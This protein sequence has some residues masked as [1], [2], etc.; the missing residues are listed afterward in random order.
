MTTSNDLLEQLFQPQSLDRI[1]NRVGADPDQ[2]RT[3]IEQALP[4]LLAGLERNAADPEGAR[5]LQQAL[6]EDR[7]DTLLDDLDGYLAGSREGK[8]ADG[9]GILSHILGDRQE[10]AAQALGQRS[11]ISG[12]N[13]LQLLMTLA[14]LV[15]GMLG[16]KSGSGGG[17]TSGGGFPD[18]GQILGQERQTA[19]SGRSD[20]GDILE[21]AFGKR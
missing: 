12:G 11:G 2:T 4:M 15:M 5:S 20:I 10:S 9:A 1:S 3:A 21:Q 6:T 19:Q 7:H 8:A 14:P 13:I 17:S 18:L 16:K